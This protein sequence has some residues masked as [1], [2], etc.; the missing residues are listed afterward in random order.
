[1]FCPLL[2]FCLRICRLQ[3][4]PLK[5]RAV[6]YEAANHCEFPEGYIAGKE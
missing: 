1:M 5:T 3:N 2:R 6:S 4:I